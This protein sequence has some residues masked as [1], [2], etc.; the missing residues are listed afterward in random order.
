MP[1]PNLPDS[2]AEDT[3]FENLGLSREDLGMDQEGSGNEDLEGSGNEPDQGSGN[4]RE[5]RVT[6]T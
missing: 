6:H 3:V 4:E 2:A 5:S 1:K